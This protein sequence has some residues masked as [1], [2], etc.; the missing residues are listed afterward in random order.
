MRVTSRREIEGL[1]GSGGGLDEVPLGG[2]WDFHYLPRFAGAPEDGLPAPGE[3]AAT[4]PVPA[5]WDDHLDRLRT[6][7][8]WSDTRFNPEHRR[9]EFPLG[10]S[11]P[12]A[13]LPYLL[14]IGFYRKRFRAPDS[15]RLT[16]EVG[17]CVMEAWA[18]LNGACL[19]HHLGH[20]TPFAF[21]LDAP[22]HGQDNEL[23]IAVS[24]LRSDRLGCIIRGWK[25][26][27][28]GITGP[29]RIKRS[30]PAEIRDLFVFP[31]ERLEALSWRAELEGDFAGAA[32]SWR[33]F[34][35]DGTCIGEG[36]QAAD[37]ADPRWQTPS[38]GMA[39]WSDNDP[40]L[41]EIAVTL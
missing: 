24:N 21:R 2:D 13:S 4:M 32:L 6:A 37:A 34:S 38:L 7:P 1:G 15:G 18:W 17:G 39:P 12:D 14:G 20:S 28:G 35:P 22:R 10:V 31:D 19:G 11:P 8:C 41:Y 36:R 9:I 26:R 30:G 33:V 5:Y 29:V 40:A 16:L 27:S 25:G 3:F 23:V